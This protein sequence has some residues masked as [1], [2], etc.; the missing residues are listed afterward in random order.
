MFLYN[1]LY[2]LELIKNCYAKLKHLHPIFRNDEEIVFESAKA[3]ISNTLKYTSNKLKNNKKIVIECVKNNATSLYHASDELKND[4]YVVLTAIKNNFNSYTFASENLQ[5]DK[6]VIMKVLKYSDNLYI[7][8]SYLIKY[9][10]I[11]LEVLK[12]NKKFTIN[13]LSEEFRNDYDI[14]LEAVKN[15]GINLKFASEEL[16]NN[17]NIVLEAVKNNGLS[18]QFSSY[19]LQNNK[20]IIIE[21]I[22]SNKLSFNFV[23]YNLEYQLYLLIHNLQHNFNIKFIKLN[24]LF[25]NNINYISKTNQFNNIFN[26]ILKNHIEIFIENYK[27]FI[28][29]IINNLDYIQLC[30]KYNIH[31]FSKDEITNYNEYNFDNVKKM[32]EEELFKNKIIL[33]Y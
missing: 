12:K 17:Y 18:I 13:S 4:K 33:Y 30:Q 10:I 14:V 1:R 2:W 16:Q 28:N 15:K 8:P 24:E 7:N 11:I 3:D 26:F 31:I 23:K 29:V 32:Y 20:N 6:E 19:T 22:L 9:K 27:K 21:S 25:L 5:N